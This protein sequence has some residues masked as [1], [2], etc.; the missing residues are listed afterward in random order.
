MPA[1]AAARTRKTGLASALRRHAMSGFAGAAAQF[2]ASGATLADGELGHRVLGSVGLDAGNQPAEGV[3]AGN[4]FFHYAA[5]RLLDRRGEPLPVKGLDIDA[6]ANVIGVSGTIK[7]EGWPYLS[8]AFAVPI[9]WLSTKADVPPTDIGRS[10][11]GDIFVQPLMIGWRSP[12]FDAVSSFS[13]Y[14]PTGQLNREGLG[15]PQW[16]QQ[17]SLGG[18]VFFD[19]ERGFRLSALASYN[20][21]HKKLSIDLTRGD[22]VQLQ[23]G[24]G[25]RFFRILDLGVAAYA[26]WQVADDQGSALPP[27][28]RGA[29]ERGYGLGPEIGVTVPAL[30]AKLTA[31]Y[32]WDLGARARPEGQ[33]LVISFSFLG[34][35][36][37]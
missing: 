13:F 14:A 34:W 10:G 20:H 4:R 19:D 23:G 1:E 11:L 32:E 6:Y 7:P 15:Q 17:V 30:R 28:A 3:Y 33:V 22:T 8:A 12:R 26:L 36:P 9:A 35:P 29:R 25:G 16:A 5:D 37:P 24:I 31:R 21:Y 18:T 27:A 2:L